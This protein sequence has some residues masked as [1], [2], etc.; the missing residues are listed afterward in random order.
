MYKHCIIVVHLIS[1]LK[2]IIIYKHCFPKY[3]RLKLIEVISWVFTGE[4]WQ[5]SVL[6][7]VLNVKSLQHFGAA[8]PLEA[9]LHASVEP[10][11]RLCL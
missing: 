6:H 10:L 11:Q 3:V 9:R 5:R 1:K 2:K 4:L 7:Q 8:E